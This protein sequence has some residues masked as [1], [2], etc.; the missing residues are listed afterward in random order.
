MTGGG[1]LI[2][3]GFISA[4]WRTRLLV[5]AEH[6]GG[7]GRVQ[8]QTDDVMDLLHELRVVGEFEPVLAVWLELKRTPDPADGRFRQP[9]PLGHLRP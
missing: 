3:H 4:S 6:D 2:P 1:P 9:G 5:H 7:L 8:I